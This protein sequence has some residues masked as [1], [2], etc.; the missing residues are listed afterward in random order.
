MLQNIIPFQ[1]LVQE[2]QGYESYVLR[3]INLLIQ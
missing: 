1:V 2:G 3:P